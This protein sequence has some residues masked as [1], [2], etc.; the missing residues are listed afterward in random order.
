MNN[1]LTFFKS[2][3]KYV[4]FSEKNILLDSGYYKYKIFERNLSK[5]E[6]IKKNLQPTAE[7][8]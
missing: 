1:S 2:H 3:D 8:L 7:T 5:I 4:I 6:G